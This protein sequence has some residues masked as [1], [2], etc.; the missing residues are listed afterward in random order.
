MTS[1]RKSAEDSS[2]S[3]DT[4]V[5]MA[6]GRSE[7]RSVNEDSFLPTL[8]HRALAVK[9]SRQCRNVESANPRLLRKNREAKKL[10]RSPQQIELDLRGTSNGE[11]TDDN[12]AIFHDRLNGRQSE[13]SSNS[14]Y[15]MGGNI[16]KRY[17]ES[18]FISRHL[19]APDSNSADMAIEQSKF[20]SEFRIS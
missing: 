13:S 20:P 14:T 12:L 4:S 5:R 19:R 3:V 18:Q 15:D 10:R 17:L 9:S 16:I 11:L 1:W 2:F 6:S 7:R 8:A